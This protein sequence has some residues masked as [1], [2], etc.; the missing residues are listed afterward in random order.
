VQSITFIAFGFLVGLLMGFGGAVVSALLL[1]DKDEKAKMRVIAEAESKT[2]V[3][4]DRLAEL[5]SKL[6]RTEKVSADN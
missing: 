6:P 3:V 1:I 4:I 2:K 5:T